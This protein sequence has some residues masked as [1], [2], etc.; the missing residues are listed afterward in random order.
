MHG[1]VSADKMECHRLLVR[2]LDFLR[3][4]KIFA[5]A[6]WQLFARCQCCGGEQLM[7]SGS[8]ASSSSH[9]DGGV[10]LS[11]PA[12]QPVTDVD[13]CNMVRIQSPPVTVSPMRQL[14]PLVDRVATPLR[15]LARAICLVA[16]PQRLQGAPVSDGSPVPEAEPHPP[17]RRRINCKTASPA[18]FPQMPP[19]LDAGPVVAEEEPASLPQSPAWWMK[20]RAAITSF[21][22][23]QAQRGLLQGASYEDRKKHARTQFNLLSEQEQ[24]QWMAMARAERMSQPRTAAGEAVPPASDSGSKD[25]LRAIGFLGTWNGSWG[26]TNPTV[27]QDLATCQ[28][29]N[30]DEKCATLRSNAHL[31][32]V[33]LD[34]RDQ[35]QLFSQRNGFIHMSC[36]M[37]LSGNSECVGRVHLHCFMSLPMDE[38]P[39]RCAGW[40]EACVFNRTPC[41]H[42]VACYGARNKRGRARSVN[43]GHFYLQV[44]KTGMIHRHANYRKN[45]H[46]LVMS[47]W[48]LDLWKLRKVT[49]EAAIKEIIASRDHALQGVQEVRRQM[50]LE[51]EQ[52]CKDQEDMV[53]KTVGL[54]PFKPATD[55]EQMWL[56][57]YADSTANL[58]TGNRDAADGDCRRR[59]YRVLVYDG[60]S[61]TGKSERAMHWFTEAKTLRLNCQ[62]VA[63]PCMKE[64]LNGQYA[65]VVFEETTWAI[66]WENRQLFQAGPARVLLGQ[67]QC[68]EHAYSVWVYAVPFIICSNEFWSGCRDAV[69]KDWIEK[70][71]YYQL[72]DT[73]TWQEESL[74]TTP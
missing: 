35:M 43:E 29:M 22:R 42:F 47:R 21:T 61:R 40:R 65:A 68:N 5:Y 20:K 71:I 23:H 72:W 70:N 26:H 7:S 73:P 33:F 17:K 48:I 67:S 57:Q 66:M 55:V 37:E 10:A 6:V 32:Q 28:G 52:W 63:S 44:N 74:V 34:F 38:R 51:Y 13:D 18:G 31:R 62:K 39:R 69:A 59:R 50:L 19:I 41:S 15:A 30:V 24:S 53:R 25:E 54:K 49:H 14:R 46:Y 4:V 60:P 16:S 64:F 58:P 9:V 8:S 3:D 12:S 2:T 11:L 27:L 45:E 1:L 36:C 56:Q